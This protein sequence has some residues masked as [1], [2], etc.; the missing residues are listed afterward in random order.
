[1]VYQAAAKWYFSI[2]VRSYVNIQ[3]HSFLCMKEVTYD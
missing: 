2:I 1:M 3:P